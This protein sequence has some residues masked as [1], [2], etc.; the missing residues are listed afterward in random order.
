VSPEATWRP[1]LQGRRAEQALRTLAR[2]GSDLEMIALKPAAG[3][4]EMGFCSLGNGLAG[5]ALFFA[6]LDKALPDRGYDEKAV[7]ILERALTEVNDDPAPATLFAGFPG[8]AWALEHFQTTFF[9]ASEE[10]AGGEAA[11][12]I[13][14]YLASPSANMAWGLL[15]GLAGLGVYAL[16]RFPRPRGRECLEAAVSRLT[17]GAEASIH[18]T[19][20]RTPPEQLLSH[21]R[22]ELPEGL[23]NLGMALGAPGIIAFLAEA[24]AVGVGERGLVGNAVSWLL[25]QKLAPS[26]ESIFPYTIA[27]S[28]SPAGHQMAWCYGD[29]GIAVA[30]LATARHLAEPAWEKTAVEIAASCAR[31]PLGRVRPADGC[32]CHGT[33]GI[34]HLFNRL[35]QATGDEPFRLAAESWLDQTLALAEEGQGVGGFCSW[36]TAIT[37]VGRWVA[38]PG[39]LSGAS[40]IGLALTAAVS[41]AEPAWD[42]LLL[43]TIP[44]Q[45]K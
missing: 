21:V 7:E 18:G 35:F 3:P 9:G 14:H 31:R 2:L 43:A 17:K 4:R 15:D 39:Y 34:F 8:V 27:A 13:E 10:D 19:A 6:Y 5:I 23:F 1:I 22:A 44:A 20:W 12:A 32:L 16:E 24:F 30:L 36:H 26:V 11:A 29:L 45:P 38:D 41:A 37:G 42:R 28:S 33:A 25:A 40:G